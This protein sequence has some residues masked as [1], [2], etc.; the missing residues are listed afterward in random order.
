MRVPEHH[1]NGHASGGHRR[2]ADLLPGRYREVVRVG[3]GSMGQ[4]YRAHDAQLGRV[5]AVKLIAG[6]LADDRQF[7]QRF[8]REARAAAR[9]NHPNVVVVHDVGE[10]DGVP[11][12]VMEY[13]GGGSIAALTAA[14]P[15]FRAEALSWI[16]QAAGAID[17]GHAA[18]VVHR[19]I[20]PSNLLLTEDGRLKVTDFGVARLVDPDATEVTQTGSF[21]GS[22]GYVAPEVLRGEQALPPA[23]IY[24]LGVVAYELFT[25]GRPFGD[26]LG[27]AEGLAVLSE[28]VPPASWRGVGLPEAVDPVFGRVLSR[29]PGER[30][31]TAQAF[32]Q[33]L[34]AAMRQPEPDGGTRILPAA[35]RRGPAPGPPAPGPP[36]PRPPAPAR[37]AGADALPTRALPAAVPAADGPP[38]PGRA[39][40]PP[41]RS[42]RGLVGAG[43]VVALA[44]LGAAAAGYVALSGDDPAP[45][46]VAQDTGAPAVTAPAVTAPP[47]TITRVVTSQAPARVRTVTQVRTAV[48]PPPAPAPAPEP[49]AAEPGTG[50]GGG[51]GGGDLRGVTPAPSAGE[52]QRLTD[53]VTYLTSVGR[54]SEGVPLQRSALA[55]YRGTSARELY[56]GYANYNL[57]RA[58]I[59][60]GRCGE[61]VPYLEASTGFEGNAN[62]LATRRAALAEAR[63]CA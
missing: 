40:A 28:P 33:E 18:H 7:R 5:V 30:P 34:A 45:D 50:G 36:A 16:A 23:D 55:Y 61:A 63:R 47:V 31:P 14:R 35:R 53:R 43:V 39:S 44:A 60:V 11:Y 58:L 29:D 20:K 42:R 24:G 26:R 15:A 19:D 2:A 57:G 59:D 37:D 27:Q 3:G 38:A 12:M 49:A 9:I 1:A 54:S 46:R 25:G 22:Y 6:H 62:Q 17:A 4:V 8:A 10:W 13:C 56:E 21:V 51:G 52:A 48:A 32:A 41:R